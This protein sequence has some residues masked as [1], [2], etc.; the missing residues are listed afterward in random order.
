MHHLLTLALS[1][2]I[3]AALP[4]DS[5][6]TLRSRARSAEARFERLARQLAPVSWSVSSGTDCDEIV[7]RFCLRFDSATTAPAVEEPGRA[8]DARREAVEA[9]RR[10]FSAAPGE[11]TAAGPLVRLLVI[12]G[13]A[14]EAVSSAGAFAALSADTLW[15][16]LLLGYAFHWLGADTAAER[17]FIAALSRLSPEQQREWLDIT[18]LLDPAERG[19]V[20]GLSPEQRADYE[21]RFWLMA[22]PFWMTPAN[23]RWTEHLSRG[24]ETRLL[25]QVPLVAGMTRW[26]R[27][28]DQLTMR[29]GT[30]KSRARIGGRTPLRAGMIEYWDTVSRAFDPGLLAA[31]FT[32]PPAPGT[33]P[34]LYAAAARSS[35]ALQIVERVIEPEHQVSRFLRRDSVILRVDAAVPMP[36]TVESRPAVALLAFDSAFTRRASTSARARTDGDTARFSLLLAVPDGRV[37]YS[38]ELL[39]DSTLGARARY[40]LDTRMPDTGPVV[41][42]VL[43]TRP[44][45][46]GALPDRFDDPRLRPRVS[47][48]VSPGDTLGVYAEVYR[49]S[50]APLALELSLERSGGPSLLRRFGRWL[51]LLDAGDAARVGW[52]SEEGGDAQTI[53]LNL[54]LDTERSGMHDLVLRV[55]DVSTGQRSESRRQILIRR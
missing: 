31:V 43:I 51:G 2:Q 20:R 17:H 24:V 55:T 46:A 41:S 42:D 45:A 5:I 50:G 21:R 47:L 35:Y 12:D 36:S 25:A 44:F 9:V 32:D 37:V 30:P 28:L 16:D 15:G 52:R 23:E 7:G 29:Y 8:V 6:E 4:P 40:A 18:W 3:G 49:L 26:G 34:A 11:L 10:Y 13:R 1:A 38:V 39:A 19:R 48:V 27:D 14:S 22:D 33:R 54:P 53:A